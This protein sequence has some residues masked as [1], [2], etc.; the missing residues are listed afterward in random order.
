MP[1][2]RQEL[3]TAPFRQGQRQDNT[4]RQ[5]LQDPKLNRCEEGGEVP[6]W[7]VEGKKEPFIP[8]NSRHPASTTVC[9]FIRHA[10]TET[11]KVND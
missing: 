11:P 9:P 3:M 7:E 5:R 8:L 1:L 10:D 2:S 4:L 6:K